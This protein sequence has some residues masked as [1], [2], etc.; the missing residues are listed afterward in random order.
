ML[1]QKAL[2]DSVTRIYT[3]LGALALLMCCI[4][5]YTGCGQGQQEYDPAVPTPPAPMVSDVKSHAPTPTA[6][7]IPVEPAPQAQVTA[8]PPAPHSPYRSNSD[9][10]SLEE[11]IVA[12]DVIAR[13]RLRSA[14]STVDA[15]SWILGSSATAS[16]A[17]LEFKFQT[18]EYLKG[19][20]RN[21]LL[22]FVV[23]SGHQNY[24][25]AQARGDLAALIAERDTRWDNREAIIFLKESDVHVQS[26]KQAGRYFLGYTYGWGGEGDGYT[27]ASPSEKQWL[28]AAEQSATS[29]ATASGSSDQR[30]FLLDAPAGGS[31]TGAGATSGTSS[32]PT[33]TLGALKTRVSE[34]GKEVDAG[35]G[36]EEYRQCVL[37]KYRTERKI[38][39]RI[40]EGTAYRRHD[41]YVGSGLPAGTVT[42]EDRIGLGLLPNKMGRYWFEGRD[43]D[44]FILKT[45]NPVPYDWSTDGVNDSVRYTRRTSTMRPL[46]AGE[47]RYFGNVMFADRLICNAYS[48]LERNLEETFVTVTAPKGVLHE[49]FFDPASLG[50]SIGGSSGIVG[51]SPYGGTLKPATFSVNSSTTTISDLSWQNG[52]VSMTL[53]PYVSLSGYALKIIELDGTVSLTLKVNDAKTSGSKKSLA[54]SVSSQPWHAGD[55]LMLRIETAP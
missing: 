30:R 12:S 34:L 26:T 6:S 13:V 55:K 38:R 14:S 15:A 18:L 54:W 41:D 39:Q 43:K 11:R 21:E 2:P 52:T 49:A 16:V 37:D 44:L 5:L 31:G 10:L 33:I 20:G 35:D 45:I 22:V 9:P 47:Y 29:T 17:V 51:V 3:S 25:E 36:S 7:S 27:V 24:T 4:A 46:P 32:T 23:S 53:T 8:Q 19:T 28:P 40:R 48:E 42:Y 50:A 1:K